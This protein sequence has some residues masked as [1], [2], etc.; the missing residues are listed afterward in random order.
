MRR[1]RAGESN[2][3]PTKSTKRPSLGHAELGA[4][5]LLDTLHL[6]AGS[7]QGSWHQLCSFPVNT[8]AEPLR[9]HFRLLLNQ[10]IYIGKNPQSA[11]LVHLKC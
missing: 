9:I 4:L 5:L 10:L 6:T 1:E 8:S 2:V 7:Y 11:P 3:V